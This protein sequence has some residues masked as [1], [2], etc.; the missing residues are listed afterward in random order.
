MATPLGM[1]P[2][3]NLAG[4]GVSAGLQSRAWMRSKVA[5][6]T[7]QGDAYTGNK[8]LTDTIELESNKGNLKVNSDKMYIKIIKG[9]DVQESDISVTIALQNAIDDGAI[10]GNGTAYIGQESTL[11]YKYSSAYAN[12]WARPIASFGFG[13]DHQNQNWLTVSNGHKAALKRWHAETKGLHIRQAICET[14]SEN[15]EAAPISLT[16]AIN[17]NFAFAET[18]V[19]AYDSTLADFKTAIQTASGLITIADNHLTVPQVL[20]L[21]DIASLDMYIKPLMIDG[22][23]MYKLMVA[24][25]EMRGLLDSQTAGTYAK[26]YI[27]GSALARVQAIVPE[28]DLV[29]RNIMICEDVRNPTFKSSD[30]SWGYLGQ[31]RSSTRAAAAAGVYNVNVLCGAE[32][33][34][35]YERDM[36]D[37]RDQDD[38]YGR[39]KGLLIRENSGCVL[40]IFDKDTP[41]D[42]TA[43][44][45]GSM[46]VLTS[47][48]SNIGG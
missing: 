28:A 21:A 1:T 19:V 48:V 38:D 34:M 26:D 24:P 31:G 30:T 40:P 15:L 36:V 11:N 33:I 2:E 35:D 12:D 29:I 43:Q 45:E 22:K 14:I 3:T 4:K 32:M 16:P 25:E 44:Y 46:L 37:F 18:G 10:N 6:E 17:P 5:L 7:L 39:N 20:E 41:T 42:A 9:K 47:R 13:I 23:S 27:A 8:N